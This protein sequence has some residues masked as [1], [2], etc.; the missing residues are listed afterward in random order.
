MNRILYILF[1]SVISLMLSPAYAQ[2]GDKSQTVA[3]ADEVEMAD[4]MR[5]DGKIYVVVAIIVIILA[6]LFIFLFMI[7][8]KVKKLEKLVLEKERQTK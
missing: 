4:A 2:Q 5:A 1:L 3:V 8:R 7:D 6:G